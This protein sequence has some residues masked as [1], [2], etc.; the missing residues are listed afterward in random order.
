MMK[1]NNNDH[2]SH[3]LPSH[4]KITHGKISHLSYFFIYFYL[5]FRMEMSFGRIIHQFEKKKKKKRELK[6]KIDK[7][8]G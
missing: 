1:N 3:N 6:Q 5:F 7:R 2:L 8:R 4:H